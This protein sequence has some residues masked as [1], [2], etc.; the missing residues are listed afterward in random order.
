[1][2]FSVD[3]V[4][5]I[6]LEACFFFINFVAEFLWMSS[7]EERFIHL[8]F[9]IVVS[10]TIINLPLSVYSTPQTMKY[11]ERGKKNKLRPQTCSQ[12]K[13]ISLVCSLQLSSINVFV[14]FV[15][16]VFWK[17][18]ELWFTVTNAI[19]FIDSMWN[20][21][22]DFFC[23]PKNLFFGVESTRGK[24]RDDIVEIAFAK[25]NCNSLIIVIMSMLSESF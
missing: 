17:I 5:L 22:I 19:T 13:C 7:N 21:S 15:C 8:M 1:M 9:G 3:S 16:I 18:I 20:N 2:R 23:Y 6:T 14:W 11:W 10:S 4:C 12:Y 25:I 24:W